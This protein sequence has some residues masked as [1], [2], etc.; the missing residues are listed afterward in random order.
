MLNEEDPVHAIIPPGST[1]DRTA[2]RTA[3]TAADLH[4]PDEGGSAPFLTELPSRAVTSGKG[5]G[6]PG[7]PALARLASSWR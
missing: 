2:A 1:A 3:V 6:A 5:H 7:F 4:R